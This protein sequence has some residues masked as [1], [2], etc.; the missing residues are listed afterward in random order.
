MHEWEPQIKE[1]DLAIHHASIFFSDDFL[2]LT[3]FAEINT[4]IF[5][6]HPNCSG[7][8]IPM[9]RSKVHI[10]RWARKW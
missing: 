3:L 4:T 7:V 8:N 5:A 9:K 1:H 10:Y 6:R 2:F